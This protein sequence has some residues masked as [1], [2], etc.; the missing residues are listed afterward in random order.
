MARDMRPR[1]SFGAGVIAPS[2]DGPEVEAVSEGSYVVPID[3]MEDLGC[4]SC[5]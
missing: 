2:A 5:E 4:D 3:P 1:D